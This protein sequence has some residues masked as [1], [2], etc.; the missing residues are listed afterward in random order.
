MKL[1]CLALLGVL[2]LAA[3]PALALDPGTASGHYAGDGVRVEV[4]HAVAMALDNAEGELE[5][6]NR[7]RV[8]LSQEDIPPAV[9]EGAPLPRV[10]ALARAGQ[11][12]GLLLDF[13]PGDK[14][15]LYVTVLAKPDDPRQSMTTI[16]LSHSDGVWKRL[17]TNATRAAGE[18]KPNDT[19]DLA[20]QFSAPVFNNPVQQ[21]LKGPAAQQSEPVKVLIARA[22][23]IG[24]GDMAAMAALSTK[25]SVEQL[26]SYPPSVLKEARAMAPQLV[27]EYRATKRVVIRRDT[28]AVQTADGS[29][30]SLVREDGAWKSMD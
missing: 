14:N 23:A 27:K 8:L 16:T 22:E 2:A 28:A 4:S 9:L 24:R 11:V 1:I 5:S 19:F 18:L 12:H 15:G 13:D 25:E 6:A 21:D 30:S 20:F 29:W 3:R 26:K 7:M 10:L 17:E